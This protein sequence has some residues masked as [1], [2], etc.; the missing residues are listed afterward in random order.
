MRHL[1]VLFNFDICSVSSVG[2]HACAGVIWYDVYRVRVTLMV[3]PCNS[4]ITQLRHGVDR[5]SKRSCSIEGKSVLTDAIGMITYL[6]FV[7][8][9]SEK[10]LAYFTRLVNND[11]S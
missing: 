3:F 11:K 8:R 4:N 1:S 5:Y 7:L 2:H 6:P 10:K 9:C